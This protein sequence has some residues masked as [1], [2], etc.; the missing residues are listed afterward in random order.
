MNNDEL[1][2]E[3]KTFVKLSLLCSQYLSLQ[4]SL[5]YLQWLSQ[6]SQTALSTVWIIDTRLKVDLL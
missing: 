5:I 1:T 6:L 2:K 3:D 4:K